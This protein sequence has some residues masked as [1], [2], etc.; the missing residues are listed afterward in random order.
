MTDTEFEQL[1]EKLFFHYAI[2]LGVY[3]GLNRW[4]VQ[5]FARALRDAIKND[6]LTNE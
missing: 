2:D 1:V 5:D 3:D 6:V 4:N